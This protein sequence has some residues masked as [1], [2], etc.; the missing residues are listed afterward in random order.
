MLATERLVRIPVAE[1]RSLSVQR[2]AN[3]DGAIYFYTPDRIGFEL[4]ISA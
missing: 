3:V 2:N 1:T 4:F